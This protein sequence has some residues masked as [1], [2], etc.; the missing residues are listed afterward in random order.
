MNTLPLDTD[1]E[2]SGPHP[3]QRT[4][5]N[6]SLWFEDCDGYRVFFCRHEILYRVALQ[7]HAH[8]KIIAVTLRQSRLATQQD[9]ATAFG[10]AVGTQR[11]WEKLYAQSG[12][13]AFTPKPHTGRPPRVDAA[14][15]AL[16]RRWFLDNLSNAEIARRLAVDEATVRRLLRRL[17]LSRATPSPSLF[18]PPPVPPTQDQDSLPTPGDDTTDIPLPP[19]LVSSPQTTESALPAAPALPSSQPQPTAPQLT[20]AL[21]PCSQ[22][23]TVDRNP[24]DRVGDRL[25][26]SQGLLEDAVPLF[27][28]ATDVPRAG[29]LLAIPALQEHGGLSVFQRLYRSLGAAFYGLRT[30]VFTL[31]VLALLRIKRPE[32][33]K[34]YAPQALGRLL[35][36]DRAPEVKTLRRKLSIMVERSLTGELLAELT[37]GRVAQQADRVAFL[38]LDGHVREYTGQEPLSKAKKAQRAV[39]TPATTD[40]WVHDAQGEPLLVV[41]SEMNASLTKV[42]LPIIA[43]V[44]KVVPAGQ[45]VTAVFDRGGWSPKLFARLIEAGVDVLTYRKGKTRKLA[46]DRF[47]EHRLQVD[48]QEKVYRLCDQRRVRAG[49]LRQRRKKRRRGDGPQYLWM[50]QVTV[51]RDEGRQTVTLTNRQDLGKVEVVRRLFGRWCQE[52]YFKYMEEEYALDALVEYGAEEVS[53]TADRPNPQREQLAKKRRKV[54]A[55]LVRVQA[56]LGKGREAAPASVTEEDVEEVQAEL[57]ARRAVLQKRV[58]KLTVQIKQL[59]KRVPATGIKKLKGEKK[60][61]VDTVKMIAYQIETMMLGEVGKHYARSEE[62]GRTL[63]TAIYQ[64]SGRLEV[65]EGELRITLSRQSS[66]HRTEV[67]RKLC[68]EYDGR[69][70]CFPGTNLCLRY[71]VEPDEPTIS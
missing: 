48:G 12:S 37:R 13:A 4:F 28:N 6:P 39:A 41:T 27:A 56:E 32:Q 70:V 8:L 26:A 29:V 14:Q 58:A 23:F 15:H 35:G 18:P 55:E 69:G 24:L 31:I 20:A 9:I 42:L 62:E 46:E 34:E 10:H 68:A 52:N 33:L 16:V 47:V 7:D 50:R 65:G 5:I 19:L 49:R 38:Y 25:L 1:C 40:T 22:A 60:R 71:S 53:A 63:L 3:V 59:P 61:L 54:Q 44:Q 66:P 2:P 57:R 64:S 43:D 21:E 51:L 17:G 67:L 11:R 45:R 30:T 36:L